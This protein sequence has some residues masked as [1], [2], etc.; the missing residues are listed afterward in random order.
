VVVLGMKKSPTIVIV[1]DKSNEF[2]Y[3]AKTERLSIDK[4]DL[5]L[6]DAKSSVIWK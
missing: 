5:S 6:V 2:K 4:L 1:N 3:D